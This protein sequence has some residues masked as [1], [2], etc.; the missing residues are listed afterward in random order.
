M[1]ASPS[2]P[3]NSRPNE[4]PDILLPIARIRTDPDEL[5]RL[6]PDPEPTKALAA[7]IAAIGLINAI[8]VSPDG[9][10]F[11]IVAGRRRLEAHRLLARDTIRATILTNHPDHN[12]IIKLTENVARSNLTPI[13]EAM[14]LAPLVN[15]HPQGVDGVAVATGRTVN[16]ILDRLDMCDWPQSLQVHVHNRQIT[17]AAAKRLAK[18]LPEE[19]RET[20]IQQA[21]ATG[22]NARTA[23]LWLQD[24]QAGYQPVSE[25]SE[26]QR[27]HAET[28]YETETRVD[29]FLCRGLAKIEDTISV[30]VCNPCLLKLQHE[31]DA[32]PAPSPP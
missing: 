10:H 13:E 20:R 2:D 21:A 30:R 5:N 6:D 4:N 9:D 1:E 27:F 12:S 24:T 29:C 31:I 17:L 23:A 18:I 14:Q 11:I 22:I 16:W 32:Q 15:A 25:L 3:S 28:T 7:S 26:K 8:T 19:L